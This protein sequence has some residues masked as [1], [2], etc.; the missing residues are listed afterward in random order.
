[1]P[2]M[3]RIFITGCAR[4][5]TTLLCR[6]FYAF[7]NTEVISPE[8]SIDDFCASSTESPI[9]VGKRKPLTVLSVPLPEHELK[10]QWSLAVRAHL[11]IVNII[12]DGRDVVHQNPTGPQVN[13]NRWIGCI[14]QAQRFRD[15]IAIEVRYEDLVRDPDAAQE[16]LART[17]DL[18]QKTRFSRYP[19]FVP[20][21]VFDEAEYK[22]FPYYDKRPVDQKSVGRSPRG[23]TAVCINPAEKAMFERILLRIVHFMRL[24]V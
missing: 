23:Y 24:V 2:A 10:R 16:R 7:R 8:I 3:T 11:H 12:R 4:S 22:D 1:M 14:L 15:R 9:L 6:L 18:K 21:A 5:G 17:L 20:N 13:P 19:D